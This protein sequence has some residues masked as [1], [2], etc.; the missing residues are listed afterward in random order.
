MKNTYT[1]NVLKIVK[2]VKSP[3][4]FSA[5][6]VSKISLKSNNSFSIP[7]GPKLACPGATKACEG[8]YAMKG[9]HH[10]PNVQT[11][12]AKNWLLLKKFEKKNDVDGAADELLKMIPKSA[13][14]FRIHE[15]G[16]FHSQWAVD[17]WAQV[18]KRKPDIKF[19]AYTRSF[20]LNFSP[21][22]KN[23]NFALWASTDIY[24]ELKAKQFVRRFRKSGTKH[25]YGP[26]DAKK[27]IPKNSFICPATDGHIDVIGACDKC[28][29]CIT[30][31]RV[32]KNIV[33]L[34]H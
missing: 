12:F 22:T 32:N 4:N 23:P 2:Q 16:D 17:A 21:L 1:K 26:W 27:E 30:K 10:F 25:A 11:K 15:S 20:N 8:C 29:L 5:S 7:A 14:I 19:W 6:S 33:F 31:R 9:R 34:A 24:N 13:K 3:K 28:K 18:V